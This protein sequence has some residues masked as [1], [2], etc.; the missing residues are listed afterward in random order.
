MHTTSTS[1]EVGVATSNPAHHASSFLATPFGGSAASAAATVSVS[2]HS[3]HSTGS[4]SPSAL[5]KLTLAST[6]DLTSEAS[7]EGT[8]SIA[9][10]P[11][12]ASPAEEAE[13]EADKR[14]I[15]K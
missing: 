10:K 9:S 2:S 13:F 5:P 3:P 11:V 4:Q 14:T 15:Y 8:I 7:L 12:F 6:S 1:S